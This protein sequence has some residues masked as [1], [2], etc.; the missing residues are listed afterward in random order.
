HPRRFS[1][2]KSPRGPHHRVPADALAHLVVV[3][4]AAF[5]ERIHKMG[6]PVTGADRAVKGPQPAADLV[7]ARAMDRLAGGDSLCEG[8]CGPGDLEGRPG[9]IEPPNGEIHEP[10]GGTLHGFRPRILGVEN[11]TRCEHAK[12]ST[13]DVE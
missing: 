13:V 6:G 9:G 7:T 2:A 1:E 12:L 10:G 8:R 4:V 11:G 5:L 3:H